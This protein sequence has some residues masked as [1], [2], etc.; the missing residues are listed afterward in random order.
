MSDK[1]DV[2]CFRYLLTAQFGSIASLLIYGP[3]FIAIYLATALLTRQNR[4]LILSAM[5]WLRTAVD[6]LRLRNKLPSSCTSQGF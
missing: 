5:A 6:A 2:W 4:L 3:S 1:I